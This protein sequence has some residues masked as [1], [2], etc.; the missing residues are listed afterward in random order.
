MRVLVSFASLL[1]C[2]TAAQAQAPVRQDPV[3][4]PAAEAAA[5]ATLDA[6]T[7]VP[8][9]LVDVKAR[10]VTAADIGAVRLPAPSA[11][12]TPSDTDEAAQ[13]ITAPRNFWWLVGG[14]VLAGIILAVLL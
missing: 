7:P 10:S 1:I 11:S 2:A 13:D 6:A 9:D 3:A 4:P 14:I 5:A 8:A 12:E